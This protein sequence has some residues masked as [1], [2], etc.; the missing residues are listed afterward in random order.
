MQ[1]R[2]GRGGSRRRCSARSS[3][4]A[5][6]SGP[7]TSETCQ[8]AEPRAPSM[9]RA[10]QCAGSPVEVNTTRHESFR[11]AGPTRSPP[12]RCAGGGSAGVGRGEPGGGRGVTRQTSSTTATNSYEVIDGNPLPIS[13]CTAKTF[14]LTIFT[15]GSFSKPARKAFMAT[16]ALDAPPAEMM[17]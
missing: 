2:I 17:C 14:K 7:G 12:T 15:G 11:S 5:H 9:M 10:D 6:G 4:S 13:C 16:S 1:P 8:R 3:G